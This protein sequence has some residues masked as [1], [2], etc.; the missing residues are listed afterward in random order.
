[1]E[2]TVL[3]LL[4]LLFLQTGGAWELNASSIYRAGI[5][6]QTL[7]PCTFTVDKHPAGPK[8]IAAFW[9]FKGNEILRYA[10]SV[11][12]QDSRFTLDEDHLLNGIAS[13][14]VSRVM[15]LD[16][17]VYTCSIIYKAERKEKEVTLIVHAAPQITITKRI[18]VI[19]RQSILRAAI[20]GFY[21][22]DINVKWFQDEQIQNS[23]KIST[24]Q[25]N[26]DGTYSVT[27]TMT[28]MPT[29]E[30]RHRTF[31]CRVQ[32][33]SLSEAQY[34]LEF[35]LEFAD[36]PEIN[37]TGRHV[38]VNKEN[39]LSCLITGFYL[40]DIDVKWFK[41]GKNLDH[42]SV[43]RPQRNPDGRYTVTSNVTITPTK[44][45]RHRTFSCR[46]QHESLS[47]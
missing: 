11:V 36:P 1:M 44:E 45:D 25:R 2:K 8:Y 6:S 30:D 21:P 34:K 22:E 43:S 19:N 17:G 39:A 35:Q 33:E 13:I 12:T 32:H 37:I 20:T 31:S 47:E 28:I 29:E 7:I 18:V 5:G 15:T 4:L 10:G 23:Y 27:S 38:F 24:P 3:G 16:E 46:V 42:V 40:E 26:R 9:Y 41:D 14:S